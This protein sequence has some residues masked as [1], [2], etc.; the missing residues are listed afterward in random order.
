[1]EIMTDIKITVGIIVGPHASNQRWLPETVES[2]L[3]QTRPADELLI[4]DDQANLDPTL[5]PEG[6]R[7]WKTPW[8]TAQGQCWN[9]MVGLAKHD[10]VV[11]LASDD[12]LRP[13]CLAD[14]ERSYRRFHDP[15][16]YYWFDIEYQSGERQGLASGPAMVTRGL[17][18]RTGGYPVESAVGAC[19]YIF[20]SLL[21][22]TRGKAG[23]LYQVES[24]DPPYWFREHPEQYSLHQHPRWGGMIGPVRDILS[25]DWIAKFGK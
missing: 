2:V 15:T 21:N 24:A 19:D 13:W 1:M 16:G 8:L 7:I 20:V 6:T 17:W 9:Y 23:R 22:A 25:E 10:L 18:E 11:F 14:C 4:I 5:F 12:I 3:T